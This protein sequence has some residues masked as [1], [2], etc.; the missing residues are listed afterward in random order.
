M[1]KDVGEVNFIAVRRFWSDKEVK[2]LS[3]ITIIKNS[4][5]QN[6]RLSEI[7]IFENYEKNQLQ[8]FK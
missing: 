5:N 2:N 6:M 3:F 7:G 4:L 1:S 8:N